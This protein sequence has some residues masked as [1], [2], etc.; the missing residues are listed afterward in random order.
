MVVLIFLQMALV[1]AF[2]YSI[3]SGKSILITLEIAHSYLRVTRHGCCGTWS[4]VLELK[5]SI[6]LVYGFYCLLGGWGGDLG[7]ETR[8]NM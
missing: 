3:V 6:R 8:G 5:T 4:T 2:R 7:I 1:M